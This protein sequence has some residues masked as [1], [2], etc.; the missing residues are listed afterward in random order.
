VT[1]RISLVAAVLSIAATCQVN[2]QR[3]GEPARDAG[4]SVVMRCQ[5]CG[6]IESIREVQEA[7]AV[8]APG[9]TS[10]SPVGL[11]MYIPLGRKSVNDDAFVGSVGSRQWQERTTTTRYE[12]IVRMEDGNYR[13]VPR[14]GV[15]DFSVGDRV[16]MAQGQIVHL[17]QQ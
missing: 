15:S 13:T 16:R 14:Q 12:F 6:T 5:D 17:A 2:A 10:G 9:V 4:V 8:T 3:S 11:V 7:R 1:R